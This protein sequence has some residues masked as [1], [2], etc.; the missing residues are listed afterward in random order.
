MP[1]ETAKIYYAL[2]LLFSKEQLASRAFVSSLG[3]ET[4]KKAFRAKVMQCHPDLLHNLP[5]SFRRTRHERFIRIQRAYEFLNVYLEAMRERGDEMPCFHPTQKTALDHHPNARHKTIIA[6]GGAK[7]GI[8][9]TVLAANISAGLASLGKKVVAIDL[10][11]GG[12]NLHLHL[13]IKFPSVTLQHYFKRGRP[14][15]DIC[16]DT[17]VDTLKMIAGDSSNLGM[18]N[19]MESQKEKLIRDL[20]DLPADYIVL[21]LGGDTSY[22][23]IDFFLAADERLAVTSPE[24]TSV[25]DIYNFLKVSLLRYLNKNIFTE[26]KEAE[27]AMFN[28]NLNN[29]KALIFEAT[30]T[31]S[32]KRV[33]HLEELI[34]RV[35]LRNEQW[36]RFLQN[37]IEEFQPH[38]VVNMMETSVKTDLALRIAEIAKRNLSI[39]LSTLPDVPFD[40]EVRQTV[41]YL[42]PVLLERPESKAAQSIFNVL[43]SILRKELS[44]SQILSLLQASD[45]DK[46]APAFLRF[47]KGG[48]HFDKEE[49]R[50]RKMYAGHR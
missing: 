28:G 19:I 8:G 10:D 13:G 9:K 4:L 1:L 11:L 35:C 20:R 21:D 36:G 25:L 43:Q 17:P 48:T 22:N 6:V 26:M 31:S 42:V 15:N 3:P 41:H 12:A 33:K 45:D 39:K 44:K 34:S 24:P 50:I 40:N 47:L 16:L 2:S 46:I 14:L 5:E 38:L 29:F 37:R 7:G 18:A 23:M 32:N 30:S 49:T 27:R